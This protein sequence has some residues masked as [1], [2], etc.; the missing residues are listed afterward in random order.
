V[1]DKSLEKSRTSFHRRKMKQL[2]IRERRQIAIAHSLVHMNPVE[3]G[4]ETISRSRSTLH[5]Q[6]VVV[7]VVVVVVGAN[8]SSSSF[9]LL[10][11]LGLSLMRTDEQFSN[12][13]CGFAMNIYK[14]RKLKLNSEE[15][16]CWRWLMSERNVVLKGN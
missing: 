6:A 7:V 10:L 12:L 9:L 3:H 11:M 2:R 1:G 14:R 8:S 16:Q 13:T 15:Y 4:F 5:K